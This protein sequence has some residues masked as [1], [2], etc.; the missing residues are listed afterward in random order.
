MGTFVKFGLAGYGP[1]L[2]PED[3][4]LDSVQSVCYAIR[5]E[6]DRSIEQLYD[7]APREAEAGDFE[8]AYGARVLA[9]ELDIMRRNLDWDKRAT[10]PLYVGNSDALEADMARLIAENF[11]LDVDLEGYSRLYVWEAEDDEDSDEDGTDAGEVL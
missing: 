6:L 5:D 3:R 7:R 8:A 2:D 4:P 1:E 10:A 11:P 9:D